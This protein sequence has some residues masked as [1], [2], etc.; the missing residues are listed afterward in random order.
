MKKLVFLSIFV[1]LFIP[2]AM[3][4][5]YNNSGSTGA[6]SIAIPFGIYDSSGNFGPALA[7]GDSVFLVVFYPCGAIAYGGAGAYNDAKITDTTV[8]GYNMYSWKCAIADID[9]TPTNGNYSYIFIAK[10]ATGAALGSPQ[11]GFFQLYTSEDYNTQLDKLTTTLDSIKAIL[12]TLQ[13]QDNWVASSTVLG[14]VRDT[15][16]G[17]IDSLQL[18]DDDIAL[19]ALIQDTTNIAK[20]ILEYTGYRQGWYTDIS[21][22]ADADTIFILDNSKDT[23]GAIISFHSGGSAGDPPT[24]SG[25]IVGYPW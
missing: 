24:D 19:I 7:S 3:G 6:D 4:D 2:M 11:L 16:N 8:S 12:D 13:N 1:L 22:N 5:I 17:I 20:Q 21:Q 9:G 25:K 10:D 15:V 14:S 18:W 23:V